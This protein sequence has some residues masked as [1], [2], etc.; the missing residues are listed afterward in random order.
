MSRETVLQ[1][2]D[3]LGVWTKGDQR[4]PLSARRSDRGARIAERAGVGVVRGES[5][6]D[7][8]RMIVAATP[9]I[10]NGDH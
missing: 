2:F 4:A 9:L 5:I 7:G 10:P 6:G 8:L 3:S 1:K